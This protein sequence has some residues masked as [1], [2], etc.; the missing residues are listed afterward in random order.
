MHDFKSLSWEIQK[1]VGKMCDFNHCHSEIQK[2]IRK[3]YVFWY[4]RATGSYWYHPRIHLELAGADRAPNLLNLITNGYV[5]EHQARSRNLRTK[6]HRECM[7]EIQKRLYI[8][9]FFE[10]LQVNDWKR[11]IFIMFFWISY[12]NKSISHIFPTYFWIS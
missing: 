4:W 3:M 8:N 9:W 12:C 10:F 11:H 5:S 6:H 7:L 2:Y 1:Y